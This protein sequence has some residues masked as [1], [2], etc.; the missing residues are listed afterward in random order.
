MVSVS[1]PF[2]GYRVAD[3]YADLLPEMVNR[4]QDYILSALYLDRYDSRFTPARDQLL[5]PE[6]ED[7][8]YP[9]LY[10]NIIPDEFKGY[11]NYPNK[12]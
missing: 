11:T 5:E 6:L 7:R 2:Y 8:A 10:N 1:S 9:G 3:E 12:K 4:P